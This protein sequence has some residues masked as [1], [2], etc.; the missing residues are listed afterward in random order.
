MYAASLQKCS[1]RVRTPELAE[2]LEST[3][4]RGK[5]ENQSRFSHWLEDVALSGR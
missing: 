1:V 3:C 4:G 5:V 2:E